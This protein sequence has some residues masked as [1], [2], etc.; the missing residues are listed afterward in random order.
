MKT[1]ANFPGVLIVIFLLL[2]TGSSCSTQNFDPND[3]PP[4]IIFIMADDMDFTL[5]PY[6]EHTNRLIAQEG[7]VFTNYFVT[8]PVCCPSR[9]SILRGQYPHNTGVFENS[10][11]FEQFHDKG[12]NADTI[13]TWMKRAGYTTSYMGK[14]LN[15][16]PA[17]V[18]RT[19][20]PPGWDDWRVFL[21]SERKSADFFTNYVLNEN[22][23]LVDYGESAEEYSTD[24]L[25]NKAIE[26]INQSAQTRSPFFLFIS[27]YAPHG[28]S[29]PAPRH[30]ELFLDVEYPKGE[31][32]HEA[33]T[34]DKPLIIRNIRESGG[35]FE[36]GDADA[37]FVK[38]VQSMLAVDEMVLALVQLLKQNGQ[39]DNTYIFFTSDNGF[40]MGEHDLPSG[41]MLP[42]EEDIRVPL[43]IR[44][45]GIQPNTT[46]QEMT[47][48]IDIAP[49]IAELTGARSASFVDGRSFA[50][51]F[52]QQQAEPQ[53]W[54]SALLIEIGDSDR[55]SPVIAYRGIRGESFVYVEYE[56]GEIEFYDLTADPYQLM[57]IADTLDMETLSILHAWLEE[58]KSCQTDA[59]R[60]SEMTV[61]DN[62]KY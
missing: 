37:L 6:L 5:L 11:G 7:A 8:S 18:K 41:K 53:E 10:P 27:P 23:K 48:N 54:R 44:G 59:C 36:V 50:H 46:I 52:D 21:T 1:W 19:Y 14:F 30:S 2:F 28:P 57:N 42:Y 34:S 62:I 15:L 22:G 9:A 17:G 43:L 51:F 20:V 29:T 4:N 12:N 16:Y 60:K 55:E 24:V 45:P 25:K 38:R 31:S 49:T 33:D 58:L 47:A 40:H 56:N 61:P 3:P 39:L 35:S 26:F 13:A 32:F